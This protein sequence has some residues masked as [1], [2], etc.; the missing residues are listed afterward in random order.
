MRPFIQDRV[1][2]ITKYNET[3]SDSKKNYGK[4]KRWKV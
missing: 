2:K 3:L 1:L 4:R